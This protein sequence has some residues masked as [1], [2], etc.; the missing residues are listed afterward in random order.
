MLV[1]LV[2]LLVVVLGELVELHIL[3]V[4]V[5][6]RLLRT[7]RTKCTIALVVIVPRLA[8][9]NYYYHEFRWASAGELVTTTLVELAYTNT[10]T[11]NTSSTSDSRASTATTTNTA[12]HA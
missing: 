9:Y 6:Q 12:S 1:A 8:K 7:T 5:K 2:P 10:S 11:R 4:L 3:L